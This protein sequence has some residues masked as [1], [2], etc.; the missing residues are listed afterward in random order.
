MALE[1]CVPSKQCLSLAEYI[2]KER[3]PKKND[4]L[5]KNHNETNVLF[6]GEM[7]SGKTSLLNVLLG[8]KGTIDLVV[9]IKMILKKCTSLKK[10][11][12]SLI[13]S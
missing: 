8:R 5:K 7:D 3:N 2:E 6:V 12:L 11:Y 10:L 9:G 4:T 1:S 13:T